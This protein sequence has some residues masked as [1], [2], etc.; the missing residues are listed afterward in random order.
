MLTC[1]YGIA[2][3]TASPWNSSFHGDLVSMAAV[4]IVAWSSR[5]GIH[6]ALGNH[7][8]NGCEIRVGRSLP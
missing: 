7:V 3:A 8:A 4:R 2:V 1:C 5:C 6:I